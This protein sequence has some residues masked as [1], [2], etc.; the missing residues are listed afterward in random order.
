MKTK[1]VLIS[2]PTIV[3]DMELEQA[4]YEFAVI[5]NADN[6][7]ALNILQYQ[8]ADQLLTEPPRIIHL[9]LQ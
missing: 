6:R 1:Y 8:T 3:L 4:L 7:R 2:G 5:L 9:K